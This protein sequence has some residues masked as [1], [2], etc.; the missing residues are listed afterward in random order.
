MLK[1]IE[2]GTINNQIAK[3]VLDEMYQSGKKAGDIVKDKGLT[4]VTDASAIE[5]AVLDVIENNP[6][7]A[8]RLRGGERKLTGF[9]VGRIMKAMKGK[10]DPKAVNELL[11]KHLGL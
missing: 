7:E 6:E 1:L 3:T 4:Q 10:A 2:D 8:E 9:F 11:S 5:K